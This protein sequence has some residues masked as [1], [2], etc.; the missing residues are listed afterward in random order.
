MQA[1][2]D[3]NRVVKRSANPDIMDY[4]DDFVRVMGKGTSPE[5]IQIGRSE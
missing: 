5:I 3:V 4:E 2:F 1:L